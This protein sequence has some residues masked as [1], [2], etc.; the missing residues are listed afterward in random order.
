MEIK[1]ASC[2]VVMC[3]AGGAGGGPCSIDRLEAFRLDGKIETKFFSESNSRNEIGAE[4]PQ[5]EP[6]GESISWSFGPRLV[7]SSEIILLP[8]DH[9]TGGSCSGWMSIGGSGEAGKEIASWSGVEVI[10]KMVKTIW[11]LV[12]QT[13]TRAIVCMSGLEI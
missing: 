12:T 9:G 3:G 4:S 2:F 6:D 10:L 1:A 11:C 8:L 7:L 5:L 13:R